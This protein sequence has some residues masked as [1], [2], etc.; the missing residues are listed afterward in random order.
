MYRRPNRDQVGASL[1]G[2]RFVFKPKSS[3]AQLKLVEMAPT[4][5]PRFGVP[6][7]IP[8]KTGQTE[9]RHHRGDVS[10]LQGSSYSRPTLGGASETLS[11]LLQAPLTLCQ[12]P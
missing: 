3:K 7:A 11:D 5:H 12:G 2:L 4:H 1:R 9:R 8:A 10:W 6:R